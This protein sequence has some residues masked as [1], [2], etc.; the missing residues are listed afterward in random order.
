VR[1]PMPTRRGIGAA[2]ASQTARVT[3]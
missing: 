1:R 3:A 2:R